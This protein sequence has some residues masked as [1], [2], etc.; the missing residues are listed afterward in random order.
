[1]SGND[2]NFASN[3]PNKHYMSKREFSLAPPNHVIVQVESRMQE[4]VKHGNLEL[5]ID[6]EF[7]PTNYATIS[8]RVVAL[9]GDSPRDEEGNHIAAKVELDDKVYFHY[10]VT[11]DEMYHIYDNY[12]KVPYYWVFCAVRGA[13]ILP[14]GGWTL[15]E[16]IVEEDFNQ[17][18][19]NGV[20][21]NAVLSESGLVT[22]V[23]KKPSIK[24]AR[25]CYIGD[26]LEEDI[27]LDIL[28]GDRVAIDV[29]CNF[30]NKIEG[31]E[32]YTIRQRHL[33]AVK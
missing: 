24:Y 7:N 15:C 31:K 29:N 10:L 5:Q 6:P 13:D 18:E 19:V 20:K 32:Y 25:L 21:I 23:T 26:P 28:V 11:S 33:L 4:S 2:Y 12:Y 14:I 8:G 27:W 22:S 3:K 1:M 30:T 16:K 9:P 17:V